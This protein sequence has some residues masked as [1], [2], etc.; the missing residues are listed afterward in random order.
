MSPGQLDQIVKDPGL[1]G[2]GRLPVFRCQPVG[3]RTPLAHR[4]LHRSGVTEPG[5]KRR[6]LREATNPPTQRFGV[7]QRGWIVP[8][9]TLS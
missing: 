4:K 3:H 9:Q 1:L 5:P 6:F 2:S 8:S 7:S